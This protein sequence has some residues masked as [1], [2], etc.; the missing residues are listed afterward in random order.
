[1]NSPPECRIDPTVV[2]ALYVQHGNELRAFLLGVLRDGHLA[3]DALQSTFAK[4][5]EQGH[6]AHEENLKGWLFQVAY[7]E[8]L[9]LRRRQATDQRV[10]KSVAEQAGNDTDAPGT[11]IS[12]QPD[13]L[14][15]QQETVLQV[16]T[17][18]NDLPLPQQQVVRLRMQQNLKF[19]EIASQLNQ[20]L[21]TVLARMQ[22]ALKR[23]RE[24]LEP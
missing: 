19:R 21:G 22:A 3:A 5:L 20:P 6:T 12:K 24:K 10:L 1:M 4:A 17:A 15:I 23:L 16:Q 13:E 8:A 11:A 14:S 7:R 9:A 2:A 18:L